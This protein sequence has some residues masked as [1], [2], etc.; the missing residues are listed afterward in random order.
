MRLA[1]RPLTEEWRKLGHDLGFGVGVSL[2]YATL[3]MVG[4]EG[5]YDYTANGSAVNLAARLCDEARD[6]QI[7][8]SG[9]AY[10]SLDGTIEAE[11]ARIVG[12]QGV[13]SADRGAQC[14]DLG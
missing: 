12:A 14:R 11:A 2:G 13:S 1:M 4:F 3:G 5:R 9:R 10:A 8:I 7:L 6:G